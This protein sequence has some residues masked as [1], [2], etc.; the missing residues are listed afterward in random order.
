MHCGKFLLANNFLSC[1][2]EGKLV[3]ASFI[4][5]KSVMESLGGLQAFG[6]HIL[7][8]YFI[9]KAFVN[10]GLSVE[11][12]S[13]ILKQNCSASSVGQLHSRLSRWAV[14]RKGVLPVL[15]FFE[16]LSTLPI[17]SFLTA[18]SLQSVYGISFWGFF[19]GSFI[20]AL[21]GDWLVMIAIRNEACAFSK[22]EFFIAWMFHQITYPLLLI[23]C[24]FITTVK[25][26]HCEL[27]T[28]LIS[29]TYVAFLQAFTKLTG[30][31]RTN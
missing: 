8:D 13:E 30:W 2:F 15:S 17:L 19:V 11:L 23:K 28:M 20:L 16:I 4:F 26:K 1:L 12:S 25:W 14:L 21:I 10:R 9:A 5:R 24:L 3:G 7:E 27:I 31:A 18:V 22:L 29:T 6:S